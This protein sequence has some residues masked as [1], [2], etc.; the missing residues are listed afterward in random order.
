MTRR[1]SSPV[2]VAALEDL[3]SREDRTRPVLAVPDPSGEHAGV[4]VVG[5]VDQLGPE[6]LLEGA[7]GAGSPGG[8]LIPTISAVT[9]VMGSNRSRFPRPS[10]MSAGTAPPELV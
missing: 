7:T 9:T 2:V 1:A 6:V 3:C 5:Q 8:E 10:S 4:G